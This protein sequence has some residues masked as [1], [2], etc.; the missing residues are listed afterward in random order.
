MIIRKIALLATIAALSPVISNASSETASVKA[1]ASAFAT[2]LASAGAAAPAFKLDYRASAGSAF[3]DFF[4]TESTF[5]LVA[6]D[7][8]T[9]AVIA[10]ANC[11][12]DVRGNVT[13]IAAMPLN[14]ETVSL[15]SQL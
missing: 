2:S 11:S 13:A 9:G 7:P 6:H 8:K 12:T 5:S 10:R 14:A 1:C 3:A 4:K 15:T